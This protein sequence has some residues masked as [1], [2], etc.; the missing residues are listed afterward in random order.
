MDRKVVVSFKDLRLSFYDPVV[1]KSK[2]VIDDVNLEIYENSV[3]GIIGESGSGKT[4]LTTL[5]TG[6]LS[7]S[8]VIEKGS[9]SINGED[10]TEWNS[11]IWESSKMRGL[12]VGQVFQNPMST[13]TYNIKIG[14]QIIES[15]LY[16]KI[17]KDADKAFEY[18]CEML[19]KVKIAD[20]KKVMDLYPFELSGGMNQRVALAIILCLKPKIIIL[21]EPTT[22]LDTTVQA[23]LL[24]IIREIKNND[25]ITF[26]YITHD[27]GVISSIADYIA[28]MYAG[29]ILEVGTTKE[30][31]FNSQH[32][33]TW[34]LLMSMPDLNDNGGELWNI[35]GSVPS[36]ISKIKGDTFAPR[37]KFAL[38]KDLTEK[39][40]MFKVSETHSAATW[41]LEVEKKD[42]QPPKEIVKRWQKYK[43]G[44]I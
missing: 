36:D 33:Y 7:D 20:P 38:E 31:L 42:Y 19:R 44:E 11:E 23:E 6:L 29:R 35:P 24:E 15:L 34:G 4:V 18:A 5:L 2:L 26:I 12:I 13:L 14:E 22:A 32:P 25:K 43:N 17:F 21:D 41:L 16:N 30:V 1:K 37:N 8:A 40:P 27:I 28:I 39:P 10:I 3:M 9:I